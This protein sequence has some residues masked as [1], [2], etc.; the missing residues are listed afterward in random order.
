MVTGKISFNLKNQ[1]SE[2]NK[3]CSRL[4]G[5]CSTIGLDKKYMFEVNLALDE[6]FTN[7]VSYGYDDD[8]DHLVRIDIS[9]LDDILHIRIEDDGKPFNP[10]KAE[11]P[12]VKCIL[13]DRDVGGLGIFLIKKI[14]DQIDYKRENGK[15][16]LLLKKKIG[17]RSSHP[18]ADDRNGPAV[19]G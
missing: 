1:T 15:N 8:S 6:L 3:L 17:C 16:I 18:P 12:D 10:M 19:D 13:E 7:I 4:E 11:A 5:F 9:C 2:L 14:M